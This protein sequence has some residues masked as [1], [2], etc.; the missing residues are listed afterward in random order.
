MTPV[1]NDIWTAPFKVDKLGG[2]RFTIL[3][4][5]DHFVTWESEVRKRL[6]AQDP[7][8]AAAPERVAQLRT[9]IRPPRTMEDVAHDMAELYRTLLADAAS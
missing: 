1:N 4:W 5:V 6:A 7:A 2:W 9:G 8:L 3:A